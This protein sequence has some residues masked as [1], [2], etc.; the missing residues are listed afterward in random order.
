M[1]NGEQIEIIIKEATE[2]VAKQGYCGSDVADKDVMMAGFGYL[3]N[4]FRA[5]ATN[6]RD[7]T[8]C[9]KSA[10]ILPDETASV[11]ADRFKKEYKWGG[12]GTAIGATII[13]IVMETVGK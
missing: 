11:K 8:D 10:N 4:E 9:L 12:I 3:A 2:K 7:L 5:C 6:I 1:G 13:A